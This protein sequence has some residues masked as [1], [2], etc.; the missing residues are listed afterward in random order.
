M[1]INQASTGSDTSSVTVRETE[2]CKYATIKK[3]IH[4][5]LWH[6]NEDQLAFEYLSAP[7]KIS[8]TKHTCLDS[9]SLLFLA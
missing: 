4:I 3:K 9:T 8:A 5:K 2:Y 1:D 6:D 7:K